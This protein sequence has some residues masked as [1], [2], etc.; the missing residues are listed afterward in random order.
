[1]CPL[2]IFQDI[3]YQLKLTSKMSSQIH[4]FINQLENEAK[5]FL[6]VKMPL[7][8]FINKL[9]YNLIIHD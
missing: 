2:I 6:E 4:I 1:M 7:L 9:I 5:Q 3:C 8:S